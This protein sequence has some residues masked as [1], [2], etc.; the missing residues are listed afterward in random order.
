MQD[1]GADSFDFPELEETDFTPGFSRRR[2]SE[3][4]DDGEIGDSFSIGLDSSGD[5]ILGED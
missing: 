2:W 5:S 4:F 1:I 3:D